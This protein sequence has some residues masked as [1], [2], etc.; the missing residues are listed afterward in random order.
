MNRD[1][2]ALASVHMERGIA[3][4]KRGGP[5]A[6]CEA[7]RCFDEAIALRGQLPL[8]ENPGARYGLAGG[9]INRADALTRLGGSENLADAVQSYTMAI[10]LLQDPPASDDGR[11]IRR[12]AISWMNRGLSLEE[13][14]TERA[15]AEALRSYNEAVKTLSHSRHS[16]DARNSL[17]LA[18]AWINLGNALLRSAGSESAAQACAAAESALPLL[19]GT[20]AKELVAA[21]PGLK[22]RH[23]LCQALTILLDAPSRD[24]SGEMDLIGR[25]TDATEEALKLAQLWDKAG[26]TRFRPLATQFFRLSVVVYE[27]HQP[28]FLPEFLLEHLQRIAG[29]RFPSIGRARFCLAGR[30]ARRPP[31]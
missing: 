13:Q 26:E 31:A 19:A 12:L 16:A 2:D 7:I 17:V 24:A 18:G 4:M 9:W 20:E 28:H 11:F 5:D 6:I 15:T 23:I 1:L 25:M 22:A 29:P 27:K 14:G 10:E 30:S 21:E 3:L 8:A